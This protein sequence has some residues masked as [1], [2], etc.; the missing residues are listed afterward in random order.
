MHTDLTDS[1]DGH[2]V[3]VVAAGQVRG[4]S[5]AAPIRHSPVVAGTAEERLVN[6]VAS[7]RRALA[8]RDTIG[9]AKGII[10]ATMCCGAD[11]A[12]SI[13]RSQ[14]QAENRKLTEIATELVERVNRRWA[15]ER[16]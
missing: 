9:Q 5:R 14:S 15:V 1:A 4:E 16:N 2:T 12:F 11:E 3:A 13:L 10:M 6:E 8:T 7:L